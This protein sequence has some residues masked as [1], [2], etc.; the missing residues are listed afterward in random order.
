[1]AG[2]P[3]EDIQDEILDRLH[4]GEPIDREAILAR[5]P[6]HADALKRFFQLISVIETPA[7]PRPAEPS[8]LG[9]FEI[10]RELG[11]GGMGVVYEARQVSLNR[12]VALKV[13]PPSMRQDRRLLARFQREAEAAARLRHPNI[14][15]VYS[16]GESAGAPFFAMELVEGRSLADVIKAR[17]AGD[18]AGLPKAGPE[19]RRWAVTTI[20]RIAD[21]LDY[22]HGRGILHR[23]VKPGNILL[24][25]DGTPRLTDFGLALDLQASELT[26]TGEMFGSPLYMSPEQA[27]R[28]EQPVDARTDIYSLAVTL[29]ELLM[30]RMPYHGTTHAEL[31]SA[32]SS[33]AIVP[34]RRAD[35]GCPE[36]L[37]RVLVQALRSDPHDRY[38]TAGAFAVDLRAALERPEEVRAVAAAARARRGDELEEHDDIDEGWWRWIGGMLIIAGLAMFL[39]RGLTREALTF[40]G[41][42]V[43]LWVYESWTQRHAPSRPAQELPAAGAGTAPPVAAAPEPPRGSRWMWALSGFLVGVFLAVILHTGAGPIFLFGILGAIVFAWLYGQRVRVHVRGQGVPHDRPL[44]GLIFEHSIERWM[45][46]L[47]ITLIVAG[48]LLL[49]PDEPAVR[50]TMVFVAAGAGLWLYDA[51]T[52]RNQLRERALARG[53]VPPPRVGEGYQRWRNE[54]PVFS[55]AALGC[56]CLVAIALV[57]GPVAAFWGVRRH[58]APVA[59]V[60]SSSTWQHGTRAASFGAEALL[61]RFRDLVVPYDLSFES[62]QPD[63]PL[64]AKRVERRADYPEPAWPPLL[65]GQAGTRPDTLDEG[66]FDVLDGAVPESSDEDAV[67]FDGPLGQRYVA[68]T[69]QFIACP[70]G[71]AEGGGITAQGYTVVLVSGEMAGRIVFESYATLVVDGSLT[72]SV[73]AASYANALVAGDLSGRWVGREHGTLYIEGRLIGTLELEAASKVV[74]A[75]RTESADLGRIHA[76]A[77][78]EVLLRDSDLPVGTHELGQ[79]TVTVAP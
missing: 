8:R 64:R 72:G 24:E 36:P 26:Q 65:G 79:L 12:R 19:Y 32:L 31:M 48:L 55:G 67:R 16:I 62:V 54:R 7:E 14:V 38:P 50:A 75:G 15:P 21:A 77:P 9:E 25:A 60:T 41:V 53:E 5:H 34:P 59:V 37:E 52:H 49:L 17:K 11:R 61:E 22:A 18:D 27:F 1:M 70:E 76:S 73:E 33:G 23:D 78:V 69:G 42:G 56:G 45:R 13:L 2:R 57:L 30:L 6:E 43:A 47:G 58:E 71:V 35:P 51:V 4:G 68:H 10:L 29:Y 3:L 46:A 63:Q 66:D 74:I 20:A 40:I 39:G 28:S 44:R